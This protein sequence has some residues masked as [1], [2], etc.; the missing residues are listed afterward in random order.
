[1]KNLGIKFKKFIKYERG[2][3]DFTVK[4]YMSDLRQFLEH[5]NNRGIEQISDVKKDAILLDIYIKN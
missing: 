3:S 1:M 4:S 2:Y 5:L